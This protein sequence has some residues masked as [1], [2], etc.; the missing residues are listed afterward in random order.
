MDMIGGRVQG[1]MWD[2]G[3]AMTA[4]VEGYIGGG[5]SLCDVRGRY[6]HVTT[7]QVIFSFMSFSDLRASVLTC[8]FTKMSSIKD[9]LETG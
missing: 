9:L 3:V 7:I 5:L 4:V 2:T 8:H 6:D 1:V